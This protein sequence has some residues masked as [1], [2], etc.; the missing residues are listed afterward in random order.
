MRKRLFALI[1]ATLFALS[2]TACDSKDDSNN[3]NRID[4]IQESS[5]VNSDVVNSEY[6]NSEDVN[7]EQPEVGATS[8]GNMSFVYEDLDGNYQPMGTLEGFNVPDFTEKGLHL[9]VYVN[10][11][12]SV[13][14][15]TIESTMTIT[16]DGI[17][18]PFELNGGDAAISNSITIENGK[19]TA[20]DV[21]I[22]FTDE[23]CSEIT[24]LN[25]NCSYAT[26]YIAD[27]GL[28]ELAAISMLSVPVKCSEHKGDATTKTTASDT[29]YVE[30]S[31]IANEF[32]VGYKY[33]Y[34][35]GYTVTCNHM[36]EDIVIKEGEG[37]YLKAAI[38]EENAGDYYVALMCNGEPMK[39]FDGEYLMKIN[40]N[41]NTRVLNYEIPHELLPEA[42]TYS[43]QM[44][45]LPTIEVF[46]KKNEE[47]MEV[48]NEATRKHTITIE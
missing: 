39:V 12:V 15:E 35:P 36:F 16:A 41:E 20:L 9:K 32:D 21:F 46:N 1:T 8:S 2:I 38:T 30:R 19:D 5:S 18:L 13:A 37:L 33:E 22:P 29:D 26:D 25:I 31:G 10:G 45:V 11:Y 24:L 6:T 23:L 40:T 42:G 27:T 43:F 47:N 28:N 44:Y 34:K 7:S 4:S 17:M 48:L 3:S 14:E